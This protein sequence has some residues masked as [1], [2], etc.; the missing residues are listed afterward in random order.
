MGVLGKGEEIVLVVLHAVSQVVR[1]AAVVEGEVDDG[2]ISCE[3]S[4]LISAGIDPDHRYED[5]VVGPAAFCVVVEI[6]PDESR[7]DRI[8]ADREGCGRRRNG[9][10]TG[11]ISYS[12]AVQPAIVA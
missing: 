11:R 8:A 1:S 3:I 12:Y 9:A 4:K 5:L 2:P 6:D 10:S 7:I